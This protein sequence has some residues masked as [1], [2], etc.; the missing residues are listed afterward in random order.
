MKLLLWIGYGI[1]LTLTVMSINPDPSLSVFT[2]ALII[3]FS[4]ILGFLDHIG[5]QFSDKV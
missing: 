4:L 1:L 3:T 2:A 5:N